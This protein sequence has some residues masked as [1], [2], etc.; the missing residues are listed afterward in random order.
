MSNIIATDTQSTEINTGIV[1]LYELYLDPNDPEDPF[2]FHPGVDYSLR[3]LQFYNE[4]NPRIINTYSAIPVEMDGLSVSS[5]G[6]SNRPILTIANVEHVFT[7]GIEQE[8]GRYLRFKD[9][10]GLKLVKRQTLEKYLIGQP[11]TSNVELPRQSYYIDRIAEENNQSVKFELA[12]PYD[13]ENIQIPARVVIGKFCPWIYQGH[14]RSKKGGCTWRL[15]NKVVGPSGPVEIYFNIYDEPLV[16]KSKIVTVASNYSTSGNY[17]ADQVVKKDNIYYRSEIG[18][19]I[20]EPGDGTD[21]WKIVRVWEDW[22]LEK[23]YNVDVTYTL[24]ND[25]VR[26]NG[27]IW[28]CILAHDSTEEKIPVYKSRYW[29]KVDYCGKTLD[30]CKCRFQ[31]IM[32]T[33]GM[34]SSRK[35]T[36]KELPF[37][38]YPGSAKFS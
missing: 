17:A 1:E 32:S 23:T 37:G 26:Y 19:N 3:E 27:A 16:E 14:G 28:R 25:Y 38:A 4:S 29:E 35:D 11:S 30:S 12:T 20:Y 8:T 15:D 10:V 7:D 36:T 9:L 13:L 2:C 31:A 22:E 33:T 6:A 21:F 5:D 34:A 24:N 18:A